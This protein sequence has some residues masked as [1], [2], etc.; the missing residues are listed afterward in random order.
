[1]SNQTFVKKDRIS[2]AHNFNETI[3][4]APSNITTNALYIGPNS[5]ITYDGNSNITNINYLNGVTLSNQYLYADGTYISNLPPGNISGWAYFVAKSNVDMDGNNI[6]NAT[7]IYSAEVRTGNTLTDSLYAP[8]GVGN[9]NVRNNIDMNN[10]LI[11]SINQITFFDGSAQNTSA[12]N[13]VNSTIIG[14]GTFGYISSASGGGIAPIDLY[15]TVIGLGT[16]GYISS[17]QLTS[18]L[19]GLGT[20]GYIS[21]SQLTST[22]RGLGNI[23]LSTNIVPSTVTGLTN[24]LGSAGYISSSQLISTT[25]GLGNIYISSANAGQTSITSTI[26]GL[27]TFA[28]VSSFNSISSL[29]ISSGNLFTGVISTQNINASTMTLDK[30]FAGPIVAATTTQ[31]LYPYSAGSQI[32]F[33]SNTTQNGF[34]SE[35]HF[36]STFTQVIQPTLD[37]NMFSNIIYIN[38]NI[39]TPNIFVSTLVTNSIQASQLSSQTIFTSTINAKGWVSTQNVYSSNVITSNINIRNISGDGTFNFTSDSIYPRVAITTRPTT[40]GYQLIGDGGVFTSFNGFQGNFSSIGTLSGSATSSIGVNG[41]LIGS[42]F[43]VSALSSI[44][45]S[46]ATINASTS[47]FQTFVSAPTITT[48]TLNANQL[49]NVYDTRIR[50]L[51]GILPQTAG[52][53]N[54]TSTS[55]WSASYNQYNENV[56]I[57]TSSISV[58]SIT[59]INANN[60][61]NITGIISAPTIIVS[62][63]TGDGS[64]IYNLP[65]ISS[66]SLQSTLRGLGTFGYISTSQLTSSLIG[67]GTLG[68][69]ST[70]TSGSA[71]NWSLYPAIS[72]VDIS[73]NI[74]SNVDTILVNSISSATSGYTDFLNFV[75]FQNNRIFA[76]TD[77]QVDS[78]SANNYGIVTFINS[79]DMNNNTITNIN[80]AYFSYSFTTYQEGL[81][82]TEYTD[83]DFNITP[84]LGLRYNEIPFVGT[85]A[86]DTTCVNLYNVNKT[87]FCDGAVPPYFVNAI[88]S[89][90]GIINY[91]NVG[92][93][94]NRPIAQDW[95]LYYAEHNLVM[96]NNDITSLHSISGYASY[97]VEFT[98]PIAVGDIYSQ[99]QISNIQVHNTLNMCNNE[100]INVKLNYNNIFIN[101]SGA[102]SL[103][104]AS[105]QTFSG[106]IYDQPLNVSYFSSVTTNSESNYLYFTS[107][108]SMWKIHITVNGF[109][110]GNTDIVRFIF[111]LSNSTSGIET[112]LTIYD[113]S[114]NALIINPVP[115][116]NSVSLSLNDTV[117]LSDIIASSIT[118]YTPISLNMYCLDLCNYNFINSNIATWKNPINISDLVIGNAVAYGNNT[119]IAVGNDSVANAYMTTSYDNGK[120]WVGAS[121]SNFVYQPYS[122]CYGNGVWLIG[123][124]IGPN[125][126]YSTDA[127]NF[128]PSSLNLFLVTL[129]IAYGNG[130]YVAAGI[131]NSPNTYTIAYSTDGMTWIASS[132]TPSNGVYNI[133]YGNGIFVAVG[134]DD[135]GG[136]VTSQDGIHWTQYNPATE[137][138]CV[139]YGA[140]RWYA[141]DKDGNLYYSTDNWYSYTT[142]IGAPPFGSLVFGDTLVGTYRANNSIYSSSDFG[143]NW[144]LVSAFVNSANCVAFGNGVYIAVG[145]NGGD[146]NCILTTNA[147]NML[148]Y[149]LEPATIQPQTYVLSAPTIDWVNTNYDINGNLTISWFPVPNAT[150][151]KVFMRNKKYTSINKYSA[152]ATV[153]LN[154]SLTQNFF[155]NDSGP[156]Y[157]TSYY[158]ASNDV[159]YNYYVFAYRNGV[160]SSFPSTEVYTHG[161]NPLELWPVQQLEY[162]GGSNHINY[163]TLT[164]RNLYTNQSF[165]FSSNV[166][167]IDNLNSQQIGLNTYLSNK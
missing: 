145:D 11:G 73:N 36:K 121:I 111:T 29:N 74:I 51:Q 48:T 161:N 164:I 81:Y 22:V 101:T 35:G 5:A 2:F 115:T 59:S 127:T 17:S 107:N 67:L 144:T 82:M 16:V 72:T 86:D 99:N 104:A 123:S 165:I 26:V 23:Y 7:E 54:G 1:M 117:N 88:F 112:P 148:T 58:S 24:N 71:S 57:K 87:F 95:S 39:S 90:N 100:I 132:S 15:S 38:G 60:T 83:P 34:Y 125:I 119:W 162:N 129:G 160:R 133:A 4:L 91:S 18:T 56:L 92:S 66:L 70:A 21:S 63:I 147:K 109:L 68:Y 166:T 19:R 106:A 27:G 52:I 141:S 154:Y 146:S 120:T 135:L 118:P 62:S 65:A 13:I 142:I 89:C 32:G 80:T 134:N 85:S 116:V 155:D 31:N 30:L 153:T 84:T 77:L 43:R 12:D 136:L 9:I 93:T 159:I 114:N 79:L 55:P 49:S 76:V 102:G 6:L 130:I 37:N 42:N 139:A 140:G 3:V 69:I 138:Y 61:I 124:Y 97:P 110:S 128:I 167:N 14:L 44:T 78:I 98:S 33:G 40:V 151:Y 149:T 96:N 8:N 156:I 126:L 103:I 75:N 20:V 157:D 163:T 137:I 143:S 113:G 152:K 94:N 45:I 47:F 131:S 46:T 122:V 64:Q 105:P 158:I 50:F 41:N 53:T 150:S 108:Q 25:T 28:Y 10:N